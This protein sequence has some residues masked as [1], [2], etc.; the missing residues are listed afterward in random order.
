MSEAARLQVIRSNMSV[1]LKGTEFGG[2]LKNAD[3]V[4]IPILEKNHYYL[5]CFDLQ[6]L[7]IEVIDNIDESKSFVTLD[8]D[9]DYKN[10]D[11]VLKVVSF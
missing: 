1:I 10:K 4:L 5:V 8:D 7:V 2:D 6:N 3:L 9:N 11:T